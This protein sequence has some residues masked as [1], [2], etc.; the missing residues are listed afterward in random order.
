MG[1]TRE[2]SRSG[3]RRWEQYRRSTL[4]QS[5]VSLGSSR[6]AIGWAEATGH[7]VWLCTD[8]ENRNTTQRTI[9]IEIYFYF[10]IFYCASIGSKNYF[11][12]SS[13]RVAEEQEYDL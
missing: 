6:S 10:F 1:R 4:P 7:S 8:C 13:P 11:Y 3:T 9:I 12:M 5:V 2:W